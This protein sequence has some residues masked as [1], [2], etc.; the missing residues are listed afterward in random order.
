M[1]LVT[2][3]MKPIVAKHDI[4]VIKELYKQYGGGYVAPYQKTPY[5]LNELKEAEGKDDSKVSETEK[6]QICAGYI[7]AHTT[8]TGGNKHGFIAYIPAGTEFYIDDDFDNVCAKSLFVTDE[9]VRDGGKAA[10]KENYRNLAEAILEAYLDH[11]TK[12]GYY[13]MPDKSLV[14]PLDITDE[15][16]G[17]AIAVVVKYDKKTGERLAW[18]LE[19][20]DL[21]WCNN[22]YKHLQIGIRVAWSSSK[23]E[24]IACK[25]TEKCMAEVLNNEDYKKTPEDFPAFKYVSEFATEGTEAGDWNMDAP[26][27]LFDV[28]MDGMTVANAV[29][30]YTGFGTLIYGWYWSSAENLQNSAWYCNTDYATVGNGLKRGS[31]YVRPSLALAAA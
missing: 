16:K 5:N 21:A 8:V 14:S 27:V 19:Q 29:M 10:S 31:G 12:I 4:Y 26:G 23:K 24:A 20:R 15:Q 18:A 30:L 11:E 25:G 2:N 17:K 22:Y 9:F 7:H 1:C 13:V 3:K 6:R 28:A